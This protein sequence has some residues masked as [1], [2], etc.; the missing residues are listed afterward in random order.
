MEFWLK[1]IKFCQKK[2][3]NLEF[4]SKNPKFGKNPK[5][6]ILVNKSKIWNFG[7]KITNFQ[8]WSNLEFWSNN[9]KF[10]QKKFQN[11]KFWSKK[12]SKIVAVNPIELQN[13]K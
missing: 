13:V 8:F 3:Q 9:P 10:G 4:W 7:Q 5:I 12:W 6:A 1:N 2:N 11:L